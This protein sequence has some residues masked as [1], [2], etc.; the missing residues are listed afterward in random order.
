M[1]GSFF[2]LCFALICLTNMRTGIN[3]ELAQ[4]LVAISVKRVLQ[5]FISKGSVCIQNY[6]Y[7]TK[8]LF[9]CLFCSLPGKL[10]SYYN[11][12]INNNNNT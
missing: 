3:F 6:Y 8:K 2:F 10:V 12:I 5:G 7:N 4:S 11:K 9:E 1:L